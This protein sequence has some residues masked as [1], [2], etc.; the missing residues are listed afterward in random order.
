[1]CSFAL[2]EPVTSASASTFASAIMKMQL[3]FGFCHTVVL[4]RDSKFFSICRKSLDLLRMNCHVLSC[5]NHNPMLVERLNRYFNKGLRIMTNKHNSVCVA[6]E[7]LLLLVYA[8]NLCP[9]PG[10]DIS[11][12]LVAV[13]R[14]FAFPINFSTNKHR[15]LTSSLPSTVES[16]SKNLANCLSACRELAQLL[17]SEHPAWHPKLANSQ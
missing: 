4:D 6:L 11:Q 9:I 2:L 8:W 1:M 17:V 13:G 12:S 10:T 15:K 3:R 7:A 16:Y 5:N 14:K